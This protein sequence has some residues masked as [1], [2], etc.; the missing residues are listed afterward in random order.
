M[1][2]HRCWLALTDV[3]CVSA[4]FPKAGGAAAAHVPRSMPA[5]ALFLF[6]ALGGVYLP[7]TCWGSSSAANLVAGKVYSDS[8]SGDLS[9]CVGAAGKEGSCEVDGDYVAPPQEVAWTASNS[10]IQ[11]MPSKVVRHVGDDEEEGKDGALSAGNRSGTSL[12]QD[13]GVVLNEVAGAAEAA[14]VSMRLAMVAA[15]APTGVPPPPPPRPALTAAA[16]AAPSTASAAAPLLLSLHVAP[17]PATLT[18][19]D[20]PVP[21]YVGLSPDGSSSAGAGSPPILSRHWLLQMT[22]TRKLAAV[23]S[24]TLFLAYII[25]GI[26]LCICLSVAFWFL[27]LEPFEFSVASGSAHR[28]SGRIFEKS[29]S[30]GE[31]VGDANVWRGSSPGR[32][33]VMRSSFPSVVPTSS[34]ATS[35]AQL[36]AAPA[37]RRPSTASQDAGDAFCND[38]VVP[39]FCECILVVPIHRLRAGGPFDITDPGGSKVLRVEFPLGSGSFTSEDMHGPSPRASLPPTR[40]QGGASLAGGDDG[41][42][43]TILLTAASGEILAHSARSNELA[44]ADAA[45]EFH[46]FRAA[47]DFFAKLTREEDK[48]VLTTIRGQRLRFWGAFAHFAVNVADSEGKL[49]ATTET[50]TVEFD[51]YG[52][53]FRLRVAP[54]VDVGLVICSLLCIGYFDETSGVVRKP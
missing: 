36:Q 30:E 19:A 28:P 13:G 37:Q 52:E 9:S 33:D 45:P 1:A 46:L 17:V 21:H 39:Q 43:N 41:S 40:F 51:S 35:P 8:S 44:K 23:S 42:S 5:C 47:G 11:T 31:V 24:G 10:F 53:F 25:G 32:V 16:L 2:Q 27:L 4:G 14:G 22:L 34:A 49:L 54:L 3:E 6:A 50:C 29:I 12:F 20:H 26:G 15:T 7:G 18:K 48:Y 38:L